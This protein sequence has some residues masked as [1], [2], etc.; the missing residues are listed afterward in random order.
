[1]PMANID[2]PL[3]W[4]RFEWN[5]AKNCLDQILPA[6]RLITQFENVETDR[7][8][9][10]T[11][12]AM[13]C[14]NVAM[15]TNNYYKNVAVHDYCLK[16]KENIT[17]IS[18]NRPST[19][20]R[21]ESTGSQGEVM[22]ENIRDV[23]HKHLEEI[24]IGLAR[25][26]REYYEPELVRLQN[27]MSEFERTRVE[28]YEPELARR[29]KVIADYEK[30]KAE[31]F[32]PQLESR[33]AEITRL[34]AVLAKSEPEL[35]RLKTALAEA[36]RLQAEQLEP[37][38]ERLTRHAE[39]ADREDKALASELAKEERPALQRRIMYHA[40]RS[41]KLAAAARRAEEELAEARRVRDQWYEPELARLREI[42]ALQEKTKEEWFEPQLQSRLDRI[43]ELE[44]R[45]ASMEGFARS[46][47]FRAW[48]KIRRLLG[49]RKA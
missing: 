18:D 16:D 44:G 42:V 12:S 49:R 20:T 47:S 35:Q 41:Q 28:W 36:E 38:I 9:M 13:L 17:L 37:E 33:Q 43:A 40:E 45:L 6:A 14:R 39:R 29:E 4:D 34:T 19:T 46:R 30:T 8:H 31:W 25:L 15:L 26:R 2:I 11:L 21:D 7:L 1:M 27:A 48:M 10:A 5:S 24:T 3:L 32:E 22:E 23:N